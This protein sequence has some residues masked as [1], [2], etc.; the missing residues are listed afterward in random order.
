M[1]PYLLYAVRFLLLIPMLTVDAHLLNARS[2]LL[3]YAGALG[4]IG[5]LGY[6]AW[7]FAG[8]SQQIRNDIEV[9]GIASKL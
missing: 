6:F 3:F 8:F 4:V 2:D 7:Q 5:T 9:R 1:K